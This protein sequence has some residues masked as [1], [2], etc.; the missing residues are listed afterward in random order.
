VGQNEIL[1]GQ[2]RAKT[3]TLWKILNR[4]WVGI[5]ELAKIFDRSV[6]GQKWWIPNYSTFKD[7]IDCLYAVKSPNYLAT[8]SINPALTH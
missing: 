1:T 5:L 8:N 6:V 2:W 3:M 4:H 7:A